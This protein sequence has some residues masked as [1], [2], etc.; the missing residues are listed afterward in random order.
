MAK[1]AFGAAHGIAL[2]NGESGDNKIFGLS[3]K[4]I[5][6]PLQFMFLPNTTLPLQHFQ[7][8]LGHPTLLS[9]IFYYFY[10]PSHTLL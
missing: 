10:C 9:S 3:S 2:M 4:K 1:G 5:P 8:G 6:L 7:L